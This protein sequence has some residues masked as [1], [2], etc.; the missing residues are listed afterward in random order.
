MRCNGKMSKF[1]HMSICRPHF[2]KVDTWKGEEKKISA[3]EEPP[4]ISKIHI[5]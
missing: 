3:I 2:R 4:S 5:F 1:A